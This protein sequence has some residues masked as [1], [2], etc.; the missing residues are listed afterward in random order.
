MGLG[1][2]AVSG[3]ITGKGTLI[4]TNLL[5]APLLYDAYGLPMARPSYTLGGDAGVAGYEAAFAVDRD[6]G[7]IL[8][9]TPS[10]ND[11]TFT[12]IHGANPPTVYGIVLIGHNIAAADISLAKFEG[13]MDTNYNTVSEDLVIN[14]AALTPVY[15]LLTSPQPYDHWR[16][17]INFT[18]SKALQIGEVFL[19]GAAPLAFNANY[20]WGAK[21]HKEL[22]QVNTAGANGVPRFYTR[23]ERL[24]TQ[25]S[26]TGISAAQLLALQVAARNGHV[27]FSPDGANGQAYFGVLKLEAPTERPGCY[28]VNANFT[29]AAS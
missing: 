2:I 8:K 26:F 15:H 3:G 17:R 4:S 13:G 19:T 29:E 11:Q 1:G 14:A 18:S 28:D 7:T 21:P 12:M 16:I 27:V 23:W 10:D 6:P 5:Y 25:F 24:Y 9:T 20:S 22:G